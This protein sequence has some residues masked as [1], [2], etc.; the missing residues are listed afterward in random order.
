MPVYV[1]RC[2]ECGQEV[3]ALRALGDT[4]LP[5]CPVCQTITRRVFTPPAVKLFREHFNHLTHSLTSSWSQHKRNLKEAGE[6]LTERTG[7]PHSYVPME[8]V[9]MADPEVCGVTDHAVETLERKRH[10]RYGG[11][12][13]WL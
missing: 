8:P 3:Q 11:K 12:V 4:H 7:I 13:S 6:K 10:E 5:L 1:F 9:D 2:T